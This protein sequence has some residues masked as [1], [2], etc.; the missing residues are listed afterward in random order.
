MKMWNPTSE[1]QDPSS[2]PVSSRNAV[3]LT[4][5]VGQRLMLSEQ[6]LAV[7]VQ[8]SAQVLLK[9]LTYNITASPELALASSVAY[10]NP[11]SSAVEPHFSL[12][13]KNLSHFSLS[14][15]TTRYSIH[16]CSNSV[17]VSSELRSHLSAFLN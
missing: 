13:R 12:W 4:V 17:V 2:V 16:L 5:L 14:P 15:L 7:S 11:F 9:I 3:F 6:D 8:P 10:F 1:T